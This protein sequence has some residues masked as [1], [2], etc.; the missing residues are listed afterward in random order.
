MTS[1]LVLTGC[2]SY[3]SPTETSPSPDS[4]G[5]INIFVSILVDGPK[6]K[7]SAA[8]DFSCGNI[9]QNYSDLEGLGPKAP[10]VTVTNLSGETLASYDGAHMAAIETTSLSDFGYALPKAKCVIRSISFEVPKESTY[11]IQVA[12][13]DPVTI[14]QQDFIA[15]SFPADAFHAA[16]YITALNVYFPKDAP[17]GLWFPSTYNLYDDGSNNI[18]WR[19]NNSIISNCYSDSCIGMQV[20]TNPDESGCPGGLYAELNQKDASGAVTGITNQTVG[21]LSPGDKANLTFQLD[22][23]SHSASLSSFDCHS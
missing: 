20:I 16:R 11:Q 2:G 18:A 8:K 21:S 17:N 12:Q 7:D 14:S 13:R 22:S 6:A 19:W 1:V 15:K 9:D 10:N 4:P 23:G 5:K 3:S